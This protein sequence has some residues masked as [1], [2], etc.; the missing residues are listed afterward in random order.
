V[1]RGEGTVEGVVTEAPEPD[2]TWAVFRGK[3]VAVTGHTGFKGGWLTL[4][5]SELGAIVHGL[6]LPPE[7]APAL[8]HVANVASACTHTIGDVRDVT[9]VRRFLRKAQPDFVFQL[10]AQ[11]L[12]RRSYEVP[13]ET[14]ATNVMGTANLLD[15][16]R[17][18]GLHCATVVVTS[19]KCYENRDW[20]YGYREHDALGGRDVYSA[21]KAACEIVVAAFQRSFFSGSAASTEPPTPV[22]TARAGNVIGGGDWAVDRIVPDAVR[23]IAEGRPIRVRNPNATRPWQHVLEPLG[24]YLRLGASLAGPMG[25]A[26][27][28]AWNFGP[29]A[30]DVIPVKHLVD[31]IV[32]LWGT[33]SWELAS[34]GLNPPEAN[35]LS[36]SIEKARSRLRWEPRWPLEKALERT[37]EWYRRFYSGG[38]AS[39]E[40]ATRAQ[41]REFMDRE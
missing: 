39:M 19:D 24:G 8:F 14:I 6:A 20:V 36:L 13:L 16:I 1:G 35:V 22:A 26:F 17:A 11:S 5:L 29:K 4:W 28:E 3:S 25:G 15:A 27:A 37:I 33:G 21:S 38:G 23:A 12:V 7:G 34:G 2:E 41:I 40:L 32:E 18:E 9:T 10:A 30:A 31:R